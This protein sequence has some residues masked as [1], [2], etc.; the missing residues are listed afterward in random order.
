MR[1]PGALLS[2]VGIVALLAALAGCGSSEDGSSPSPSG[3][4]SASSSAS[5]S[6]TGPAI[7]PEGTKLTVG[8]PATIEWKPKQSVQGIVRI[9][10]T[11]LQSTTY[12]QT[13][14]GWKLNDDAKS[15][16]PY[17][18]RARVTNLGKTG[19]GGY[20]VPLYGVDAADNLVEASQFTSAFKPCQPGTL[21]KRFAPGASANVCL[22][23]LVPD[24]GKLTGV[25][26]RRDEDYDPITWTGKVTPYA[27][28]APKSGKPGTKG[29]GAK[30]G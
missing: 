11:Q 23:V 4:G 21:P 22:V 24:K 26:Y 18:V 2:V 30:K 1:R 20:A 29:R 8:S 3:P 12:A 25:S 27:P 17:F 7:T 14:Q 6:P 28:A 16:S 13:F 9:N 10:V 19:L 5:P 15:R